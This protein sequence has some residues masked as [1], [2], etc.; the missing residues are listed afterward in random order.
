[1]LWAGLVVHLHPEL[2]S[3][4]SYSRSIGNDV[5]INNEFTCVLMIV[6]NQNGHV[7]TIDTYVA[8]HGSIV[9]KNIH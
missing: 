8:F 3:T 9:D 5:V 2:Q 4:S 6:G 7:P 1:M